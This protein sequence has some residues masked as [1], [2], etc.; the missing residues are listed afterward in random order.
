MFRFRL[1]KLKIYVFEFGCVFFV[2]G[3]IWELTK[4]E[5]EGR[6]EPTDRPTEFRSCLSES[7]ICVPNPASK[8]EKYVFEFGSVFCVLKY[9]GDDKKKKKRRKMIGHP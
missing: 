8:I 7:L 1:P 4:K 2:C 3:N 9:L 5:E 6:N